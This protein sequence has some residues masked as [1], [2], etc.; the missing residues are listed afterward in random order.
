MSDIDTRFKEGN[1][2]AEKWSL[3]DAEI[4]FY[5]AFEFSNDSDDC[6]CVED[7]IHHTK[8]PYSTFYNLIKKYPVLDNIKNDIKKAVLR[9]INKGGLLAEFNPAMSIWRLKQL[10][11]HDVQKTD[12]T[13]NGKD[14]NNTPIINFVKADD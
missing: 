6:L 7:A 5:K 9:R 1:R 13:T 4:L 12:V 2:H 11:E 8:I 3:E 14:V 10:G